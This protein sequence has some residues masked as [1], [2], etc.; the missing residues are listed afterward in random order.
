[1]KYNAEVDREN[2]NIS[3]RNDLLRKRKGV[4]IIQAAEAHTRARSRV[5]SGGGA[6]PTRPDGSGRRPARRRVRGAELAPGSAAAVQSGANRKSFCVEV[7][8]IKEF[9]SHS[10]GGGGDDLGFG[11]DER[12][13]APTTGRS[14]TCRGYFL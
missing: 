14:L 2:R 4:G 6:V 1:M 13:R 11:G 9:K 5:V 8:L 12:R 7:I 3:P 10:R